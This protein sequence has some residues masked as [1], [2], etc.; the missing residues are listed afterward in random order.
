MDGIIEKN[1]NA[2]EQCVCKSHI[3]GEKCDRCEEGYSMNGFPNCQVRKTFRLKMGH[4]R[5]FY[6]ALLLRYDFNY[7]FSLS[8]AIG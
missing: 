5:F 8:D 1:C 6:R 2:K 3:I 7:L 4:F